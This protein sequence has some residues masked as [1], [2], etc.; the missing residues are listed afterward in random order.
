LVD[1]LGGDTTYLLACLADAHPSWLWLVQ[2]PREVDQ[3][4]YLHREHRGALILALQQAVDA[5]GKIRKPGAWLGRTVQ[6]IAA[7]AN[8]AG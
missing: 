6:T 3:L 7:R 5:P 8:G 1:V 4:V 2:N